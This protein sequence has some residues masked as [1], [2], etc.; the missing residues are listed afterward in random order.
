[1]SSGFR[2]LCQR[3]RH[4]FPVRRAISPPALTN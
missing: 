3:S 1:L 4:C 2:P